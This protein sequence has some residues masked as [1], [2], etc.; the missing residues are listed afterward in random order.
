MAGLYR[1]NG[2]Q[3][4]AFNCVNVLLTSADLD[5]LEN[6]IRSRSLP[7]TSGFF[8]GESDGSEIDDDL[9]F[10]AKA[11]EAIAAGLMVF[12]SSWW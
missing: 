7:P 6:A 3:D 5:A 1:E 4:D 9:Q 10:V 2:G 12:Y 11:R 8:F